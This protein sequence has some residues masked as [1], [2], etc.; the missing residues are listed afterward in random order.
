[1]YVTY[2]V[3]HD[4]SGD[5]PTIQAAI[6]ATNIGDHIDL[7]DGEYKG[8]GNRDLDIVRKVI[9][10]RSQSG[11]PTACV[12]N[13]EGTPSEHHRGFR[14]LNCG[15]YSIPPHNNYFVGI[16]IKN[17][18]ASVGGGI[19]CVASSLNLMNFVVENCT[20]TEV[21]GAL[22]ISQDSYVGVMESTLTGNSATTYGGA[23]YLSE[24]WA[25]LGYGEIIGNHSNND[26]GGI[27]GTSASCYMDRM[28]L[29]DNSTND[30]GGGAYFINS[31]DVEF[32]L[33]VFK[34]NASTSYGGGLNLHN[35][36]ASLLTTTFHDNTGNPGSGLAVRSGSDVTLERVL[37]ALNNAGE[38]LYL[39]GASCTFD[40]GCTDIFG[41]A[42]GD[43]VGDYL[44]P[45]PAG[46]NLAV[47]PLFCDPA[48]D[49]LGVASNS[50]CGGT[51]N[52]DCD[53]IGAR[54]VDCS[55]A[56]ATFLVKSDRTGDFPTI[57]DAID[58]SASGDMIL[59]ADGDFSG[60][61]NRDL[62]FLSLDI[63]LKSENDDPSQVTIFCQGSE[64]DPHRGFMMTS[65][66]TAATLLQGITITGAWHA[67]GGGLW[68]SGGSP[69]IA[70]CIFSGN[71]SNNGAGIYIDGG[72]QPSITDC[73]FNNNSASSAG[74]GLYF[75]TSAGTL[76]NSTFEN[77]F[78]YWGGGGVHVSHCDAEISHCLFFGNDGR[79]WG[80]A[81]LFNG[82]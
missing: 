14:V 27:Y 21:G 69:T 33:C 77:N 56:G 55:G 8:E 30:K 82:I 52:P 42:G 78:G 2:I 67:N 49:D 48:G 74:G 32:E 64:T 1:M 76:T 28:L 5:L 79:D 51:A 58:G 10:I 15:E 45:I 60:P 43:W 53:T 16:T 57:Q 59:L 25:D 24:S 40:I 22:S 70:N 23:V 11:D 20:A 37:V 4:R 47:N 41:N 81:I 18:Y 35:T 46:N 19:Y 50:M 6:D 68:I 62:D 7:L 66:Q 63:T 12:I 26:G 75:Q 61:G 54:G 34:S 17:G 29:R 65:G 39:D 38:G 44:D 73:T 9:Y 3:A 72:G 13:C 71:E 80:N 36:T 31:A